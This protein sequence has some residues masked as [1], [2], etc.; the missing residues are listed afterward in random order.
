MK[1]DKPA[2]AAELRRQAEARLKK[3]RRSPGSKQS[4]RKI[5][6]GLRRLQHELE[7]HQIELEMQNEELQQTQAE[8]ESAL[9]KYTTLYDFAPTGYFTLTG[10]GTIL[11]VNLTGTRLVGIERARLLN[12]RFAFLI[13]EADRPLFNAFLKKI[14]TE[15]DRGSCEVAL[16]R[17][18]TNPLFVRIEAVVSKDGRECRAAVLDVNERHNA[19]V[20]RDRLVQELQQ[21]LA[22]VKMFSG[23]LPI[24]ANCKKVRTGKGNWEQIE[25]YVRK[26]SEADFSH[27]ICPECAKQLYPDI[28]IRGKK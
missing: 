2:D 24:C 16:S 3:R 20:E 22:R 9:E 18:G 6:A 27:G 11:A 23:L 26:H 5:E 10:N 25:T 19:A 15:K 28:D 8:I 21:T 1:L 12:R 13:S 4:D 14:F 7:V 17:E